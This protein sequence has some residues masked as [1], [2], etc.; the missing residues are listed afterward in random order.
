M[1][2]SK[3]TTESL[4]DGEVTDAK[5]SAL[6]ASK[7]SGTIATARLGSGTASSSTFLRGDQT[8]AAAGGGAWTLIES[9][10]ASA[11]ATIDFT[12]G[13]NS[14][15]ST[16]VFVGSELLLNTGGGIHVLISTD[17]GSSWLSS[18]YD[19]TSYLQDSAS[20]G[21]Y[22]VSSQ[23]SWDTF[24]NYEV[25]SD[26]LQ[27]FTLELYYPSNATYKKNARSMW[28]GMNTGDVSAQ[29]IS[30]LGHSTTSA[31]DGIRFDAAGGAA[32]ITSGRISLYGISHT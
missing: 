27:A 28:I 2:L 20:F 23:S 16:Y 21:G 17:G 3:I 32:T 10:T 11:D 22:L 6:S 25:A 12:S 24:S 15:Y 1:A 4:L 13:I 29:M 14:T 18:G 9:Q 30:A 8:Y 31:I 26:N 19:R 7:L 5:I